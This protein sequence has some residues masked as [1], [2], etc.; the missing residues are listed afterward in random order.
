MEKREKYHRII[1]GGIVAAIVFFAIAGVTLFGDDKSLEGDY[2]D[3]IAII[4]SVILS[5]WCV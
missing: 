1:T 4:V 2:S 5:I 3:T